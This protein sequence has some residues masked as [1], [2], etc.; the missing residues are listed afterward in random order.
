MTHFAEYYKF[1]HSVMESFIGNVFGRIEVL[2]KICLG[3]VSKL[4]SIAKNIYSY[5]V[6][7]IV[8]TRNH[9]YY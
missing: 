7:V 6:S 8:Y 3:S 4:Y 1:D 2:R 9:Y 5:N